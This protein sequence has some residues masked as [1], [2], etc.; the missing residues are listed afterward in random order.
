MFL[1]SKVRPVRKADNFVP[2]VSRLSKQCGIRNISQTYRP[3]RPV[4]GID[5]YYY[6]YYYYANIVLCCC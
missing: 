4:T 3:P 5:Y 2:S 6:Y 1:R